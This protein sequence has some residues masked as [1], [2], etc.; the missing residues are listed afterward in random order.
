MAGR[1]SEYSE[2]VLK[3]FK[4][5][6]NVGVIK[7]PDAWSFISDPTRGVTMEL[8]LKLDGA[9]IS[10]ARFR[11]SG[12]GATIATTSAITE[13]LRGK[14]PEQ[15]LEITDAD[16]SQALELSERKHYVAELGME[17]IAASIEDYRKRNA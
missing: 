12:C 14:T 10:D 11:A 7:D 1:F 2:K 16:L 9:I 17:L 3:I 4:N 6:A 15:A 5:P 13:M 8:F